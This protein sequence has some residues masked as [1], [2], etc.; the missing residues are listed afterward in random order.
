MQGACCAP[1]RVQPRLRG[2]RNPA[3][4]SGSIRHKEWK[5]TFFYCKYQGWFGQG[6]QQIHPEGLG[7]GRQCSDK[8]ISL[9]F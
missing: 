9:T 8:S 3:I 5:V 2:Q 7:S 1:K 4:N 6:A